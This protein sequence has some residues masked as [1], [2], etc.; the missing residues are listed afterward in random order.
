MTAFPCTP[1]AAKNRGY[2]SETQ[3]DHRRIDELARRQHGLV[4]RS[5]LIELGLNDSAIHRRR[6]N[7]HLIAAGHGVY[8]LAGAPT[9]WRQLVMAAV[10]RAPLN[11]LAS[12]R[13]A[14]ALHDLGVRG[15]V[16]EIVAER[17][18]RS[19]P[20]GV[21]SHESRDLPPVDRWEVDGIAVT[22]IDRTLI[23]IGRYWPHSRVGA[24]LDLAVRDGL[25]S[26]ER[27]ADRFAALA[28]RGRDGIGTARRVLEARGFDDGWGFEAAMSRALRAAGLPAPTREH[29]VEVDGNRYYIDFAYPEV[30]LGIECDST[31]WH[32]LP[33]QFEADLRRQNHLIRSGMLLL[34]YTPSRLRDDRAAVI[35]EISDALTHRRR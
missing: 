30:G 24:L 13:T 3:V 35:D 26:Y 18:H 23:D 5:Q 9:S 19:A 25:T 4:A 33:Y 6:R 2:S 20:S 21:R 27:F 14:I 11:A 15:G 1:T 7:G 34:R 16:I 31:M 29:L 10:L 12:H 22:S 28:R 8:R 32:T 17:H